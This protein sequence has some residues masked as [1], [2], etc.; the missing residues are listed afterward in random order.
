MFNLNFYLEFP[1]ESI[2]MMNSIL[3]IIYKTKTYIKGRIVIWPYSSMKNSSLP[4]KEVFMFKYKCFMFKTY[5]Y[6]M[7]PLKVLVAQSC[8][9][10]CSPMNC[11]PP[12]SSVQGITQ[13]I[14]LAWVVM[15]FSRGSGI[16]PRS[17]V[18]QAD[19]LLFELPWKPMWPTELWG[20]PLWPLAKALSL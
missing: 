15:P 5:V 8:L 11:S 19:S 16:K 9:T 14:L 2:L 3:Q 13:A 20:K 1:L 4:L 10:L 17:P 6:V 12:G 18:L 7:W